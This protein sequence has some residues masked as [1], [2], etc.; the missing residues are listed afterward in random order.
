M[1][2][3]SSNNSLRR[4]TEDTTTTREVVKVI[5]TTIRGEASKMVVTNLT[6]VLPSHTSLKRNMVC[7][8]KRSARSKP[9]LEMKPKKLFRASE[10]TRMIFRRSDL[11]SMLLHQITS[12]ESL[13]NSESTCSESS[14]PNRSVL[15][16][17][18]TTMR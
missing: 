1:S 11:F 8:N 17:V 3:I 13:V 9:S 12:R 7:G 10:E 14:D 5:T 6:K 4:I 15:N 18:L 2:K 16:K